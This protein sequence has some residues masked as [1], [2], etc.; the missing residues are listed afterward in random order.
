MSCNIFNLPDAKADKT[1]NG[2]TASLSSTGTTFAEELSAVTMAFKLTGTDALTLTSAD[3]DITI[4]DAAAWSFTVLPIT[5]FSLAA[6]VYSWAIET[7]SAADSIQDYFVG[8]LTVKA[9]ST[10]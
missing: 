10:P 8:T 4:D 2:L 9:D 1:W 3:G 6:G 7:T 5:R